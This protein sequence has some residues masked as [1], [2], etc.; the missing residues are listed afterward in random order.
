MPL[1]DGRRLPLTVLSDISWMVQDCRSKKFCF[2]NLSVKPLLEVQAASVSKIEQLGSFE[3]CVG[4][5]IISEEF[6]RQVW[7]TQTE[8]LNSLP[9]LYSIK[10]KAYD[11]R[12]ASGFQN[13]NWNSAAELL[14][15][16]RAGEALDSNF[17]ELSNSTEIHDSIK[18][19]GK[20]MF[21]GGQPTPANECTLVR[22]DGLRVP[23]EEF[24]SHAYVYFPGHTPG[25]CC[26]DIDLTE[27]KHLKVALRFTRIK[28]EA[29]SDF[30]FW[31]APHEKVVSD[32]A[33]EC[34]SLGYIHEEPLNL[35]VVDA[36]LYC[37]APIWLG[38]LAEF[39][40]DRAMALASVQ[41]AK[42]GRRF[43][44]GVKQ[45]QKYV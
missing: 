33:A 38:R 17:L 36:D 26:L 7:R 14:L 29:A 30:I 13:S 16:Y 18:G 10:D 43:P 8:A 24:S 5:V 37:D 19:A 28:L 27:H 35:S 9:G 42:D 25:M 34:R 32:K 11:F 40:G 20:E 41:Y 45:E 39:R 15:G 12:G 4:Q 1:T 3:P 21:S 6:R 22:E 2:S 44:L 31:T 23:V